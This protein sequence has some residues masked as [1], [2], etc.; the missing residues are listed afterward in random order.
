M[1]ESDDITRIIAGVSFL[2]LLVITLPLLATGIP[3]IANGATCSNL[4]SP[5]G[6]GNNQSIM[7][8]VADVNSLHIDLSINPNPVAVGQ[9]ITLE[10]R[11]I[12]E[13]TAPLTLAFVPDEAVFRYT[14][15]ENGLM[16]FI[17]SAN[18]Q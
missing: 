14:G 10:V 7:A 12:N 1:N 4:Y 5:P 17:Q 13:S 2:L 8:Q 9:P 16:F 11:F 6:N 18:G 3:G 15:N